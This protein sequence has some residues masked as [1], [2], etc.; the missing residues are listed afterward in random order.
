M[1]LID[2]DAMRATMGLMFRDLKLCVE[3]AGAAALAA[4]L[5]PLRAELQGGR[6][7]GVVIVCGSNIDLATF[8]SQAGESGRREYLR[9][10]P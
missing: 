1:V 9:Q 7:V 10:A 3:P 8:H 5:G 2:D 6:R 4:V